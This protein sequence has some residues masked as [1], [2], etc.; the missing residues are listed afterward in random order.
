MYDLREPTP[1]A[2]LKLDHLYTGLNKPALSVIDY[3]EL[4]MQLRMS[5]TD[6][7]THFV[8]YTLDQK[9]CFCFEH[10]TCST[11]AINLHNQGAALREAAHLLEVQP[12]EIYSGT[13]CYAVVFTP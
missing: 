9:P 4:G 7:F 3:K 13:I 6:D 5:A 2:N 10:Q 1:I 11:D 8:I 12:G